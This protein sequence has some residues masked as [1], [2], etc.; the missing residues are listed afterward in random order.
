MNAPKK[1]GTDLSALK[2]RLAKKT[3]AAAPPPAEPAAPAAP[4]AA[5]PAAPKAAPPARPPFK[6]APSP[7]DLPAPGESAPIDIPPPGE[8]SAPIDIP[9][10]GEVALPPQP[11]PVAAQP[12]AAAV[13]ASRKSLEDGTPFGSTAGSFDPNAGIIDSGEVQAKGN[14]GLVILAAGA[15]L[16]FG[17]ALGWIGHQIT[18]KGEVKAV[19]QKKGSDM[20]TE[21]TK[22]SDMRKGI[23]LK[24]DELQK[25]VSTDPAKGAEELANLM[26]TNFEKSPKVDD[27]FGWQLAGIGPEGIRRTF[28]L[29]EEANGLRLDLGYLVN[30]VAGNAKALTE[31]GGPRLFAVK[32]KKDGA[33]LVERGEPRRSW[34]RLSAV[35][36]TAARPTCRPRRRRRCP[37]ATCRICRGSASGSSAA[38]GIAAALRARRSVAA[39]RRLA[40]VGR[41]SGARRP[42]RLARALLRVRGRVHHRGP[43]LRRRAG[44]SRL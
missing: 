38:A 13:P 6:K 40:V 33:V 19:A 17:V 39:R 28:D 41:Q 34:R 5:A 42:V 3:D 25:L 15:A 18:S 21:A 9:A 43:G 27:L 16:A 14:R 37:F 32:F 7:A 29:Y 26:K 35:G 12:V 36:S 22:V 23:S 30:F 44:L 20:F 1:P 8:V 10:P 11:A 24:I 31:T 2:A 4:P